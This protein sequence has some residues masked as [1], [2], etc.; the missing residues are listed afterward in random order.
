MSMHAAIES[1]SEL[2]QCPACRQ[3]QIVVEQAG[4]LLRC[5]DCDRRY[6]IWNGV[7]DLL[8]DQDR[9]LAN[10]AFGKL[11]AWSYDRFA[12]RSAF[13]KFYRWRFEDEFE[14]YTRFVELR[15]SDVVLDVGCGT[16]NYTLPFAAKLTA[17]V[18]IGLDLSTAMLELLLRHAQVQGVQ[19]VI[20]IRANAEALPFRDGCL[21]RVFNG[22]LHHVFPHVRPSL[23]ETYRCLEPGG[24]LFGSTFFATQPLLHR[25]MQWAGALALRSRSVVAAVLERELAV[26]GFQDVMVNP[27]RLGQFFFG[28]YR[29]TKPDLGGSPCPNDW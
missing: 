22:C 24:V 12:A 5:T 28:N 14:E 9:P 4:A 23:A 21:P 3:G 18:A 20:A 7:L 16:G 11:A 15:P 25:I 10:K 13:R 6:S 8:R 17:G 27:G 2:L 26:V 1:I 29:A 19:N